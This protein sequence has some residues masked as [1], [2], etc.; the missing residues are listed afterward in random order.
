[1]TSTLPFLIVAGMLAI[2]LGAE[3]ASGQCSNS[4]QP[5]C[6]VYPKCFQKYCPCDGDEDE[7]F[8][9]YGEKYCRRFLDNSSLSNVGKQWRDSTLRC[10]Q[11]TIVPKLSIS[12]NP[13]CNCKSMKDMAF[14]SHVTCYTKPGASV[15]S[16]PLSD[17]NEIRKIVDTVDIFSSEGWQQMRKVAEICKSDAPDAGRRKVWETM[18]SILDLR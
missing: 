9:R 10:L 18:H 16:L 7:Y 5:S 13:Q 12:E 15:C 14:S 2:F 3:N 17:V 6:D 1:M 4:I 8:K 11:E